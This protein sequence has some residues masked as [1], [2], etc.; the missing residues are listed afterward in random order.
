MA[1]EGRGKLPPNRISGSM[2][3]RNKIPTTTLPISGIHEL[4]GAIPNTVRCNRKSEIKDGASWT[5]MPLSR[6]LDI[7]TIF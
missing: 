5:K 1:K 4:N 3:N 6:F 2:T 7:A